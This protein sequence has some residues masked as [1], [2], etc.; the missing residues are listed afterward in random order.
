MFYKNI[1]QILEII[2]AN[3]EGYNTGVNIHN[4]RGIKFGNVIAKIFSEV[5]VSTQQ[6]WVTH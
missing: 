4:A 1:R 2:N 5:K 3:L 6:L